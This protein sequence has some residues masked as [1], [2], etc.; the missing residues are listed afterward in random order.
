MDI[1]HL[2]LR[3]VDNTGCA[4]VWYCFAR[5]STTKMGPLHE[6]S[7]DNPLDDPP[8][9]RNTEMSQTRPLRPLPSST[10]ERAQNQST[11]AS[12]MSLR[13]LPIAQTTTDILRAHT[14]TC[15]GHR[16][17]TR[18]YPALV[19]PT[20]SAEVIDPPPDGVLHPLKSPQL[21]QHWND[22]DRNRPG[23]ADIGQRLANCAKVVHSVRAPAK[24]AARS[25]AGS[26]PHLP[27]IEPNQVGMAPT[28]VEHRP[29][30]AAFG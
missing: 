24:I 9:N 6:P 8:I 11:E 2:C 21:G 7:V 20:R 10:T 15:H 3:H 13:H 5:V 23:L 26:W 30:L 12:K 14:H 19:K 22:F 27:K 4:R 28:V 18:P 16:G 1:T 17:W 25:R 29:S